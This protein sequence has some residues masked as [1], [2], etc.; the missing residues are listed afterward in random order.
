[1]YTIVQI[2]KYV[3][4]KLPVPSCPGSKYLMWFDNGSGTKHAKDSKG[5]QHICFEFGPASPLCCNSWL[6][7]ALV[8]QANVWNHARPR[9]RSEYVEIRGLRNPS[10][11]SPKDEYV[12]TNAMTWVWFR[13][14]PWIYLRSFSGNC[15]QIKIIW[16]PSH[17]RA[18]DVSSSHKLIGGWM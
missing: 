9:R 17:I 11:Y 3:W 8:T 10:K 13:Q 4:V 18:L 15:H 6:A 5:F 16:V 12:F 1:M 7:A 14:H 2:F